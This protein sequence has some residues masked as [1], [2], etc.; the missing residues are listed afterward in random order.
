MYRPYRGPAPPSMRSSRRGGTDVDR[1]PG[2]EYEDDYEEYPDEYDARSR[3][4]RGEWETANP[5][6]SD[7]PSMERLTLGPSEWTTGT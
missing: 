1:G 6:A 2:E 5:P 7:A 4:T 3:G